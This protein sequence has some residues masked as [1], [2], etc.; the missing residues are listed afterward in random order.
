MYW[1]GLALEW[2]SVALQVW[3]FVLM[4][5]R[6]LYGR[7]PLFAIYTAY[8]I[9][10]TVLR[11][12]FLSNRAVYFYVYWFSEPGQILLA[13]LAVHESFMAVFRAFYLLW[14]F[15]LLIPG[16]IFASLVYSVWNAYA[17]RPLH[18]NATGAAI[19]SMAIAAQYVIVALAVLF[20]SLL[21]IVHVRWRLYEFRIVFGFGT[22][23]LA[24]VFAGLIRSEFVTKFIF[25]SEWLPGMA[26]LFAVL[27]WLSA[28]LGQEPKNGQNIAGKPSKEEVVGELRGQLRAIKR[29][30]GKKDT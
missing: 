26:Y 4:G 25:L 27:I 20:F 10:T 21:R 13:I 7:F 2:T 1:F 12:V 15:R 17:H 9:V 19:I 14:W 11:S 30:L 16:A 5:R 6:N 29:F 3:I 24:V 28:M 23:A 22:S 18:V 8:M